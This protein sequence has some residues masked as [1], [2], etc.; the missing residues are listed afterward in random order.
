MEIAIRIVFQ[1]VAVVSVYFAGFY[2]G[3]GKALK[4]VFKDDINKGESHETRD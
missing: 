3:Y 2:I 4:D 1:I